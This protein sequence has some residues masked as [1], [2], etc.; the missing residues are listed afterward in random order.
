MSIQSV[1]SESKRN[2]SDQKSCIHSACHIQEVIAASQFVHAQ[3]AHSFCVSVNLYIVIRRF[4]FSRPIDAICFQGSFTGKGKQT[5]THFVY[6]LVFIALG[7]SLRR[8]EHNN[9]LMANLKFTITPIFRFNCNIINV[10][11]MTQSLF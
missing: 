6:N 8:A 1:V 5:P 7:E 10:Q 2:Y 3:Q 4:N 9:R 11:C